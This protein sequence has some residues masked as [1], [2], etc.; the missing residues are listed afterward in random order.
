[1]KFT[2]LDAQLTKCPVHHVLPVPTSEQQGPNC[3][4]YALHNVI[5]YY[6]TEFGFKSLPARYRDC[7]LPGEKKPSDSEFHSL[8][9]IGKYVLATNVGEVWDAE[10]VAT[11]ARMAG[12]N[13][14]VIHVDKGNFIP[15]TVSAIDGGCP[16]IAAI[17]VSSDSKATSGG[18]GAFGGEHAHWITIIG[19]GENSTRDVYFGHTHW[20]KYFISRAAEIRDSNFQL[21]IFSKGMLQVFAKSPKSSGGNRN[22]KK[23]GSADPNNRSEAANLATKMA[24]YDKPVGFQDIDLSGLR[25]KIIVFRNEIPISALIQNAINRYQSR[26]SGFSG[27]FTHQSSESKDA[28]KKLGEAIKN[29]NDSQLRQLVL[30]YMG[31]SP[32]NKP[33]GAGDPLKTNS[34]LYKTLKEVCSVRLP[35]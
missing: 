12:H 14:E 24:S 15:T 1:M 20:G 10:K 16:V 31:K 21:N 6:A 3:G 33:L 27:I 19:Y 32:G 5:Q 18:P 34:S 23:I 2:D 4:F 28:V 26:F 35:V 11:I 7:H 17:D 9:Q 25:G 29:K 8:R 22:Y 13:A 30:W